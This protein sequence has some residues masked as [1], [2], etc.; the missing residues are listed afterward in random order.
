MTLLELLVKEL[1]KRGGWP[2]KIF[3]C[4]QDD[5]CRVCFYTEG[6]IRRERTPSTWS[7]PRGSEAEHQ[8]H[9][10]FYHDSRAAD[11]DTTIVTREQY[12]AAVWNGEG[13]PPVGAVVELMDDSQS[14]TWGEVTIKFYGDAFAVWDDHGQEESNSLCHVRVRPIRTEAERKREEVINSLQVN[15]IHADNLTAESLYAII[16]SGKIAGVKLGR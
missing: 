12:E 1:P 7:I 2:S 10:S 11:A 14:S 4:A 3:Q 13:L 5:D 15:I 16:E 9:Y 8:G 6:L